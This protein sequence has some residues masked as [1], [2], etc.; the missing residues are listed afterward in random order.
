MLLIYSILGL[1]VCCVYFILHNF[2]SS[3]CF[4]HMN[5]NEWFPFL[6]WIEFHKSKYSIICCWYCELYGS[7]I[8]YR[9]WLNDCLDHFLLYT[10]MICQ[11]FELEHW[12]S[13]QGSLPIKFYE[14][15]VYFFL[16]AF[17][18]VCCHCVLA[19][20]SFYLFR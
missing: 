12:T 17:A 15:F 13:L 2:F 11:W 1:I 20:I 18:D 8:L 4:I 5:F 10:S 6:V 3:S 16:I 7:Y 14:P 19:A 9:N